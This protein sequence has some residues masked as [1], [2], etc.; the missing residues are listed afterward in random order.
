MNKKIISLFM[1][2]VLIIGCT[3]SQKEADA[4]SIKLN[5]VKLVINVGNTSK[6]KIK[7]IASGKKVKW[8]SSKPSVASVNKKG[9][10]TA[11][12]AGKTT[13]KAKIS[14]KT[15]KCNIT[16]KEASQATLTTPSTQTATT[17]VPTVSPTP[18]P[19]VAPTITPL[20]VEWTADSANAKKIREYVT[21]ISNASDKNNYIPV[22]D[23]IAVFDMDGT[24]MCETFPSYFDTAMFVQFVLYDHPEQADDELTA[25]AKK[26]EGKTNSQNELTTEE[27]AKLFAKAFK[28]L[29]VQEVYDYTVQFGKYDSQRFN[30]LKY[31]DAFYRPMVEV[32]KYLYENNFTIYVVSGTERT[33]VR[34]IVANSP[35]ADYVEP[36]NIIGTELEVTVKG[37]EDSDLTSTYQYMS[38]DELVYTGK[39]VQ[40]DVKASKTLLIAKEIGKKPV[41]AFGNT[42]GDFSMCNYTLSNNNYPSE[43]FILVAD[44]SEREWGKESNWETKSAEYTELGYNPV[45]MK[46][47]FLN[48]YHDGVTIK[49]VENLEA[50]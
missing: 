35:I 21:K 18:S 28:G 43:A 37:H 45:S 19:I 25:A 40:K 17:A 7:G 27:T 26:L 36:N 31:G 8:T 34:A 30:N 33:A 47:E 3:F 2:L 15:L 22:K 10:V 1:T 44:D 32:V 29:T 50:A 5:L 48:I 11:N 24:L 46:N 12:K 9:K 39:F 14:N 38:G 23:R 4:S 49:P 20:S 13:I 41:L 16:V 6:I 42:S